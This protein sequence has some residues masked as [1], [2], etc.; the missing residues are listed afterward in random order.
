LL[1]SAGSAYLDALPATRLL[2]ISTT[3][4]MA[5]IPLI[6]PFFSLDYPR[7][8]M[9][10]GLLQIIILVT[11]NY[12]LIPILGIEGSAWAKIIMRVVVL[13]YTLFISYKLVK[14]HHEV[15]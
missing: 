10:A 15:S 7:Y 6:A 5:T 4:T 8:F 1:V 14:A 2:L 3:I 13:F 11:G 9:F 12:V